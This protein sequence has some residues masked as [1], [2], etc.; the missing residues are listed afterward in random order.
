M[1]RTFTLALAGLAAAGLAAC[2]QAN[3]QDEAFGQKVRA[4]LLEHPEVLEEAIQALDAKRSAQASADQTKAL[5]ANRRALE[6]DP[7]DPV[8][9]QGPITVVEF[10]D[11]R[12]GFCKTAAPEVLK[13][14]ASQKDVRLVFKEF[15]ILPDANGRI[16]VS[17]RAARIALAAKGSGKYVALHQDL[18]AQRALDDAAITKVAQK[19]GL[20]AAALLRAGQAPAVDEHLA[21]TH[22]LAQKL[23]I[24]GTPAFIVGDTV[25]PGADLEALRAAI[26]NARKKRA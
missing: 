13:L 3:G 21:D 5:A 24:A 10:F 2:S 17:E 19:H 16:G 12:C 8:V 14:V 9:G 1:R 11:Y 25:V 18:M 15:P 23:S 20:D 6:A 26:A 4:Y 22:E 7:R